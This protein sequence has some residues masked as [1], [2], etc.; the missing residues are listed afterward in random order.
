MKDNVIPLS[1]DCVRPEDVLRGVSKRS[2]LEH[3]YVVGVTKEGKFVSWAS[4]DCS[5]LSDS[6]LLLTRIAT[7]LIINNQED[8]HE[9]SASE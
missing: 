4:G 8:E 7:G 3:L 9:P 1:S 5:R 2:D 6:A